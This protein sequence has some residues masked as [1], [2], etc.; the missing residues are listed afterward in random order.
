MTR[1]N[2]TG[3]PSLTKRPHPLQMMK[4]PELNIPAYEYFQICAQGLRVNGF[5]SKNQHKEFINKLKVWMNQNRV[6]FK[7]EVKERE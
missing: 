2:K 6:G 5:M 1:S 4:V 3:T 7:H